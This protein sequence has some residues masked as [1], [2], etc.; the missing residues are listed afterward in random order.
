MDKL[1]IKNLYV[2][3]SGKEILKGLN[4]VI[5]SGE[6]HVIMG[7][8]GSGK[9]TLCFA[10]MGHPRYKITKGDVFLNGKNI[11]KMSTDKRAKLGLFL[12]FQYP[13]EIP[14]ITFGNFLRIASN[15]LKIAN[16]S[17]EKPMSPMEFYPVL[18]KE[19]ENLKMDKSFI[20]R[21]LNEGFSGGEKKRAEIAQMSVLKPKMAILDEIDSGLDIDGLR[22]VANGI[23]T[24]FR[25]QKPGMLLI[26]HYQRILDFLK[27]DF[28]HVMGDGKILE[29]G[30]PKL[31]KKLEKS[32]YDFLKSKRKNR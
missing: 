25:K 4:L 21:G 18:Q 6:M 23:G 7:P 19:F 27:P 8:N 30:G 15:N 3:A 5:K 13:H 26:T 10:L 24:I 12:G 22:T 2:S 1:E 28:V 16:K 31:A 29:S 32:G 20:G 9:S 11:L 14:G 17:S